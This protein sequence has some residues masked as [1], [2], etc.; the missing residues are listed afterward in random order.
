MLG[1]QRQ[2]GPALRRSRSASRRTTDF[3]KLPSYSVEKCTRS[4]PNQLLTQW[5]P[6]RSTDKLDSKIHAQQ[7]LNH[8]TQQTSQPSSSTA[9]SIRKGKSS[10]P[11]NPPPPLIMGVSQRPQKS[12]DLPTRPEPN[13]PWRCSRRARCTCS[14]LARPSAAPWEY[15][16]TTNSSSG[17]GGVPTV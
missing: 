14:I 1:A 2:S 13:S 4:C 11:C 12:D 17:V 8:P 3:H 5:H 15:A 16:C 10:S 6:P 7:S 9:P